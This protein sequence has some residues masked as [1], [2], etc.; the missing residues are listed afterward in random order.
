M[1]RF[2]SRFRS[3]GFKRFGFRGKPKRIRK[4]RSSRGGIRL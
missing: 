2:R 1:S 3:R 4:Y